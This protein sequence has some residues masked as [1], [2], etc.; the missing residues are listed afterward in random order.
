MFVNNESQDWSNAH[1]KTNL[2]SVFVKC[3]KC[4]LNSLSRF[5]AKYSFYI[6]LTQLFLCQYFPLILTNFYSA[7]YTIFKII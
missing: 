5:N 3:E 1:I 4:V 7:W 6:I 2:T